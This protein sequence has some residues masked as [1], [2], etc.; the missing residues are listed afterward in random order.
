MTAARPIAPCAAILD[1][2]DEAG[3]RALLA[4]LVEHFG[5]EIVRSGWSAYEKFGPQSRI[6]FW[7]RLSEAAAADPGAAFEAVAAHVTAP[8]DI[9]RLDRR[10]EA[11]AGEGLELEITVA[12]NVVAV[13]MPGLVWLDLEIDLEPAV[14]ADLEAA[15][16]PVSG[17]P[18]SSGC[19]EV[20]A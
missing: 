20:S 19:P 4:P 12:A 9:D 11:A 15:L 8:A 1:A 6:W 18:D 17:H 14:Q 2:P 3:A 10:I 5:I 13:T 7:W 16:I